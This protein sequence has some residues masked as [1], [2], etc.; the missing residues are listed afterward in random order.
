[1][2]PRLE[3]VDLK[4]TRGF[5]IGAP[6]HEHRSYFVFLFTHLLTLLT[7]INYLIDGKR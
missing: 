3:Q 7:D 1:M 4:F 2:R 5:H 6:F